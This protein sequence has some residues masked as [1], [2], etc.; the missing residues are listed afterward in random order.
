MRHRGATGR[1]WGWFGPDSRGDVVLT[2]THSGA[3]HLAVRLD[4]DERAWLRRRL[5][6]LDAEQ[7][8]DGPG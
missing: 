6:E 8:T 2:M 4:A 1:L 7:D 3:A 5:E